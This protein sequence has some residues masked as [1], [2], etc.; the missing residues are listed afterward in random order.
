MKFELKL[1]IMFPF[2]RFKFEITFYYPNDSNINQY[3]QRF[4]WHRFGAAGNFCNAVHYPHV[5]SVFVYRTDF[6]PKKN[7]A[8]GP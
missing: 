5:V 8:I 7:N 2:L 6:I 3:N 4:T 1:D